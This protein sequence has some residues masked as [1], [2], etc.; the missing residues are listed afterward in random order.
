M[1]DIQVGDVWKY[2][3]G[4]ELDEGNMKIIKYDRRKKKR[5]V[6]LIKLNKLEVDMHMLNMHFDYLQ[7]YLFDRL[8]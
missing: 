5:S 3:G 4:D 1:S 8:R 7:K 6:E 2:R